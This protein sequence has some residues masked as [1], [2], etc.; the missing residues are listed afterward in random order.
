M[1]K[2]EVVAADRCA[3]GLGRRTFKKVDTCYG[4][5]K[6]MTSGVF[7]LA[8]AV[9]WAG[10]GM[11]FG[12][13]LLAEAQTAAAEGGTWRWLAK[14]SVASSMAP[15]Q[16]NGW[17][18]RKQNP[19]A[20]E[21]A[22][23]TIEGKAVLEVKYRDVPWA[24]MT[25][26]VVTDGK[27]VAEWVTG[28]QKA[29]PTRISA[30]FEVKKG[31]VIRVEFHSDEHPAGVMAVYLKPSAGE[32]VSPVAE[33]PVQP[34]PAG[35]AG[36]LVKND[37]F[38]NGSAGWGWENWSKTADVTFGID[39]T[40]AHA[41][42]KSA[43]VTSATRG[44]HALGQSVAKI[45]A[46]KR[47]QI[48]FWVKAQDYRYGNERTPAMVSCDFTPVKAV[49]RPIVSIT[50]EGTFDWKKM[51]FTVVAPPST[52]RLYLIH[53]AGTL[54][55]DDIRVTEMGSATESTAGK[56]PASLAATKKMAADGVTIEAVDVA[57]ELYTAQ[58][59]SRGGKVTRLQAGDIQW[60][61][62]NKPEAWSSGI[63][64]DW[65]KEDSQKE[66]LTAPYAL[67]VTETNGVV[68]VK[69]AYAPKDE[70]RGL[71][72]TRTFRFYPDQAS[73]D[74]CH[75]I[76]NAEAD[77]T[78]TPGLHHYLNIWR[79]MEGEPLFSV[80]V[81]ARTKPLRA[82]MTCMMAE[83]T[84]FSAT[85]APWAGIVDVKKRGICFQ[86][87]ES[88]PKSWRAWGGFERQKGTLEADF[89]AIELAKDQTWTCAYTVHLTSGLPSYGH[90]AKNV[91]V[92]VG[93]PD[94]YLFAP[95]AY[96]QSLVTVTTADG[97]TYQAACD[98]PGGASVKV[99]MPV[100]L[101]GGEAEAQV[102][103]ATRGVIKA[104][105]IPRA[106]EAVVHGGGETADD[107]PCRYLPLTAN[108]VPDPGSGGF[109]YYASDYYQHEAYVSPDIISMWAFGQQSNLQENL[110][111]IRLILDLPAGIDILGG[112]FVRPPIERTGVTIGG[113]PYA[114]FTVSVGYD[115]RKS[116]SGVTELIVRTTL[117]APQDAEMFCATRIKGELKQQRAMPLHIITVPKASPPK[118]LFTEFIALAGV[119]DD[120]PDTASFQHVGFQIPDEAYF[121][122]A[123]K[124]GLRQQ[125]RTLSA[126]LNMPAE[127]NADY[128][129][130]MVG[131]DQSAMNETLDGRK[132]GPH[133]CPT[134]RGPDFQ[135]VIE[136][137]KQCLDLGL[138][139]HFF[140]PE[141]GDGKEICFCERCRREF[142]TDLGRKHP[143]LDYRDPRE[144]MA[145]PSRY[146][147]LHRAWVVFKAE[148]EAE[149]YAIYRQQMLDHLRGQGRD[150]ACFKMIYAAAPGWRAQDVLPG[151][152]RWIFKG[153]EQSVED[154]RILGKVFDYYSPMIY[155]E[156]NGRFNRR[157]DMLE[158]PEELHGLRE[159]SD[160]TVNVCP[161]LSAGYPYTDFGVNIEPNGMMK[162]QVLEA[163][164]GGAKGVALYSEGWFDALDM[165]Q[166][167][168]AMRAVVPVED[169][170]AEGVPLVPGE[171]VD[172]TGQTFVKGIRKG[173]AAVVLV[174]EYSARKIMARV[175]FKTEHAVTVTPLS[176]GARVITCGPGTNE[177]DVELSENRAALFKV[178][179]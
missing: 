14:H 21:F 155:I 146:R 40:V 72:L 115:R 138:L 22:N 7:W 71:R 152:D 110:E 77:R 76:K 61:A 145:Q 120:Y 151:K 154:P 52:A 50:P 28:K 9:R 11:V 47:Y 148:K 87:T 34:S 178:A 92:S 15:E 161:M 33:V 74:V 67:T 133:A 64:K 171:F 23:G 13:A 113:K 38:E 69:A 44:R 91:L 36:N 164:A 20:I 90:V 99:A 6:K 108:P 95:V 39:D 128:M 51:S 126:K 160:G 172:V 132:V 111:D 107:K 135:K 53:T 8:T 2:I 25:V 159:L 168:E 46:G 153:V 80:F 65:L 103:T 162:Y 130:F 123:I 141:R 165:C 79:V 84:D 98:L 12:W 27:V 68:T 173:D 167:A 70:M 29:L 26:K 117:S 93:A 125:A 3:I 136:Y 86:S 150:P 49:P 119:L 102:R 82:D 176:T 100:I 48:E 122:Q 57:G 177:F 75:E 105:P 114:R 16:E 169:I 166:F 147:D 78:L 134:Y 42:R 94:V 5:S 157:A 121:R 63:C 129:R 24:V 137:G 88:T 112:R 89:T 55:F 59:H 116:R 10:I 175:S 41:G 43:R 179:P 131:K 106:A 45:E 140:D 54:W 139:R 142:K 30:P 60:C 56:G 143:G 83:T 85:N 58:I 97:G 144:F 73:F 18:V 37:S 156:V 101:H 96:G 31:S 1:R 170:L 81:G 4:N 104:A 118:K 62:G 19:G 109:A 174:S 163:F 32:K 66:L 127:V 17:I 124:P 158:I 35:A 149:K